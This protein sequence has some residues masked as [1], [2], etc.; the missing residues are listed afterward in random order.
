MKWNEA[1][2][3]FFFAQKL[4]LKKGHEQLSFPRFSASL[5]AFF[6]FI[7]AS[8]CQYYDRLINFLSL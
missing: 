4:D 2:I 1:E 7:F 3:E 5:I 6:L 8:R